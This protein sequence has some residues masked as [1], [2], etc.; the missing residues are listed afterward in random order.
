MAMAKQS[1]G[2]PFKPDAPFIEADATIMQFD[3][4]A[5]ADPLLGSVHDPIYQGAGA[6]GSLG[7]PRPREGAVTKAHGGVLFLDEIGELSRYQL[8]RLL[9]VLEDGKV[10][11]YSS[12]YSKSN[13]AIP[14]YIHDIFKNGMPADFR[15]IGATTR[16]PE[17]LPSALRSRCTEIFFDE[18]SAEDAELIAKNSCQRLGAD[19]AENVPEIVG[20]YCRNGRDSVNIIQNAWSAVCAE[21]R[22]QITAND[23]TRALTEGRFVKRYGVS[24]NSAPRIGVVNGLA[25]CGATGCVIA[26][27]AV[28]VRGKTGLSVRGVAREEELKGGASSLRRRGSALEAAENVLEVLEQLTDFNKED[29]HISINFPGGSVADGPSAGVAMLLAVYSAVFN[30]PVSGDIALTGEL[31]LR[32]EVLPVGGVAQKVRAAFASGAKRVYVPK[33]NAEVEGVVAVATASDVLDI[34]RG[35]AEVRR[36]V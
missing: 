2:T 33:D 34:V 7:I 35:E 30:V 32:G 18:L 9:K 22:S 29:Y 31:S 23:V 1:E 3:E 24:L 25:V 20:S 11:F 4:R 14:Q 28:A 13:K 10:M 17:E 5:I 21:K 6:F 27:E 8:N 15:L 26:V 12:Y 36:A 19:F 16:R